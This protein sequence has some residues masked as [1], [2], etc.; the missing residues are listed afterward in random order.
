MSEFLQQINLVSMCT[1]FPYKT[2]IPRSIGVL[3]GES[4]NFNLS[5]TYQHNKFTKLS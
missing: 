4:I 2:K 5:R 3:L 1:R